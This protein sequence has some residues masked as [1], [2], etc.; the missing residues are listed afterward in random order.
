M[1]NDRKVNQFGEKH[2]KEKYICRVC[3]RKV[4][5]GKA[6]ED[7]WYYCIKGKGTAEDKDNQFFN[8]EDVEYVCNEH[9]KTLSDK[10]SP[11]FVAIGYPYYTSISMSDHNIT[12]F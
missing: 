9:Y 5:L 6:R 7:E 3:K 8:Q 1:A 4:P 10:E 11:G 12:T 2:S